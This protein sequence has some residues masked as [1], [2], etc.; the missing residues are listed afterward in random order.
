MLDDRRHRQPQILAAPFFGDRGMQLRESLDMQ[1]IDD[2]IAPRRRRR[3][4]VLPIEGAVDDARA[5]RRPVREFPRERVYERGAG[6][7]AMPVLRVVGAMHMER[8]VGTGSG[9]AR[10]YQTVPNIAGAPGQIVA[11]EFLTAQRIE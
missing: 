9:A 10:R 2:G 6:I 1:L 7:E 3:P 4:I 11:G 5:R 8:I